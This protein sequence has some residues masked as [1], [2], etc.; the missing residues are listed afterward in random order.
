MKK[1]EI[2]KFNNCYFYYKGILDGE[3][4]FVRCIITQ[5]GNL[6]LDNEI[7]D[8]SDYEKELIQ[9]T[10]EDFLSKVNFEENTIIDFN[11]KKYSN[12]IIRNVDKKN[13]KLIVEVDDD[14]TFEYSNIIVNFDDV[15][16]VYP[17]STYNDRSK[18]K[19]LF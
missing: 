19:K 14:E 2:F 5:S 1:G 8:M 10:I 6:L 17:E 16:I 7:V 18:Y 9:I 4:L 15:K 13:K 3:P 11:G 12:G